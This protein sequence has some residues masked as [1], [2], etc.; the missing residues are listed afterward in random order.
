[1]KTVLV[2]LLLLVSSC[3]RSFYRKSVD[4]Y[5]NM[6]P[7]KAYKKCMSFNWGLTTPHR[8]CHIIRRLKIIEDLLKE[9]R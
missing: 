6:S 1:M 8:Q 9:G 4:A 5:D 7:N 2:A 3:G